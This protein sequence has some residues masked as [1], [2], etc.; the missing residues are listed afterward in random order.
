MTT[1]NNTA[2]SVMAGELRRARLATVLCDRAYGQ[3]LGHRIDRWFA[4][5]PAGDTGMGQ[6]EAIRRGLA[7][8]RDVVRAMRGLGG[9]AAVQN[10][11]PRRVD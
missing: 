8:Q 5:V 1:S 7:I 4:C 11:G 3:N 10:Y 6:R 2:A 9:G